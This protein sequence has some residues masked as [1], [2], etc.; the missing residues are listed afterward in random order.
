[1]DIVLKLRELRARAGLT[2][3]EVSRRCGVGVKTLSSFE[4]GARTS[5]MKLAQ[6]EAIL[7]VYGVS[8]AEFFGPGL[9]R[10]LAPWEDPSGSERDLL[11]S[12]LE[13]LPEVAKRVITEKLKLAIELARDLGRPPHAVANHGDRHRTAPGRM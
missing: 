5:T 2:Q 11:L 10:L 1:M 12:E 7:R 3:E 13:T 4:S 9:D 6:L 8:A